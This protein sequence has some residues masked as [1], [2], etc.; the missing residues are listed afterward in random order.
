[1]Q[2][3]SGKNTLTG[4]KSATIG[5]EDSTGTV[6]TKYSY[7]GS[8]ALVTNGQAMLFVPPTAGA[9]AATVTGLQGPSAGQFQVR[10]DGIPGRSYVLTASP[11]LITW[12]P[13]STNVL[14][15]SGLWWFTDPVSSTQQDRYYRAISA[16]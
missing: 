11:D 8:P 3:E 14:P 16:Q 10:L 12:S 9:P 4:G 2:V 5:I 1:L 13:L 6:A 15:A 7:Q